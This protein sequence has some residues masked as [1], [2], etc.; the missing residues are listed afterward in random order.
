[1]YVIITFSYNKTCSFTNATFSQKTQLNYLLLL[2][3]NATTAIPITTITATTITFVIIP[4]L[5]SLIFYLFPIYFFLLFMTASKTTTTTTIM[6]TTTILG[7]SCSLLS[8]LTSFLVYNLFVSE[9]SA[10]CL[11]YINS[12]HIF[13]LHDET[14]CN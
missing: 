4:V 1:M 10:N 6:A 3:T 5:L 9:I 7:I 14:G 8:V 11:G 2:F 12:S 13:S